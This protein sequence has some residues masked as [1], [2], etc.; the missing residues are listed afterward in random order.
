MAGY[1]FSNKKLRDQL[2]KA[3]DPEEAAK[4]LG[5]H[6][7]KDGKKL[8]GQVRDFVESDEVQKNIGKAKKFASKKV[9]EAKGEID[10]MVCK[11][12]TKTKRA[13]KKGVKQ[14]KKAI[15][16]TTKKAK[17]KVGRMKTRTRKL[18]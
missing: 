13:A 11:G 2:S 5:A 16:S 15:K 10:T 18:S 4:L 8:A 6:L 9:K 3:K 17:K 12:K 14:A 1:L 7:Q